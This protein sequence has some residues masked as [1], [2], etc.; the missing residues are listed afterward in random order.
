[1]NMINIINI[2]NIMHITNIINISNVINNINMNKL[3]CALRMA[4]QSLPWC[5]SAKTSLSAAA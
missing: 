1:M 4:P 3:L 2:L 5:G